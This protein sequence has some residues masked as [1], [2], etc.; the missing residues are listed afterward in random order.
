MFF[1]S[2]DPGIANFGISIIDNSK[3][4]NVIETVIISNNRKFTD[5]EKIVE[6]MYGS[7]VVK[8]LSIVNK[9][10]ELLDKYKKIEVI[11]LE[12]PFYS[13]LTPVSYGALLEVISSIKYQIVIPRNL[14]FK[15][16]EPLLVKK[17]FT[18]KGMANKEAMKQF[19]IKKVEEKIIHLPTEIDSLSEHEIDAIA[20]GFVYHLS[21]SYTPNAI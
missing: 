4:F 21:L 13:A 6:S 3:K 10:N 17:I 11:I 12:A 18:N 16:I 1:L 20:I 5:E 8:I 7:R 9:I 14:P 15:L 19:L 2:A